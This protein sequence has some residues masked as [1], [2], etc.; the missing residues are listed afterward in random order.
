MSPTEFTVPMIDKNWKKSSQPPMSSAPVGVPLFVNLA[1]L[2]LSDWIYSKL[3]MIAT[4]AAAGKT[5]ENRLIHPNS[6]TIS[7]YPSMKVVGMSLISV[8]CSMSIWRA[9]LENYS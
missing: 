8:Y 3:L 1:M 7:L 5:G 6:S 9:R 2:S 4:T